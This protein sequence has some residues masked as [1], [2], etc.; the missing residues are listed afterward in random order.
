MNVACL[1]DRLAKEAPAD[2]GFI[3]GDSRL[4]WGEIS[5]RVA[6]LAGVLR[7]RG[8]TRG[9]RVGLL[10][11]N[12]AAYLEVELALARLGAIVQPMNTRLAVPEL[13]AQLADSAPRLLIYSQSQAEAAARAA[14]RLASLAL[15]GGGP[16]GLEAAMPAVEP[17]DDIVEAA[18]EDVFGLFYTSGTTGRPK[19]VM[20]T[21]GNVLSNTRLL[22]PSIGLRRDDVVLHAAPMFHVADFGMSYGQ[23]L[24]GS[25]HCFV[26][27][28]TPSG[29]AE[30]IERHRVGIVVLVPTMIA[31][32]LRDP[33]AASRDL[34]SL[35]FVF[36]GGSPMP[37]ALLR[38]CFERL[39]C[40]FIQGY[41]QT[42]VTHTISLLGE[43]DHRRAL[44]QPSLLRSCGKP[45]AGVELRVV[46]ADDRPVAPGEVGEIVVRAPHV[47]KGYWN[48]P[49]V[50]AEALKGGWLRTGDLG[51]RDAEGY[52]YLVDRKKDMIISGG[53]NV[54]SA[55]VENALAGH[56]S[57]LDCAVI[58]V[59]DETFGERV[60]A[61]VVT[62]PGRA[63][64]AA[65]LQ[66]HCRATI[67]GYKIPRSFE[68]V[69][70]LPKTAAGKVRKALLRAPHWDRP[71][72]GEARLD[73]GLDSAGVLPL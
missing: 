59:P 63:G 23:L 20:I 66:A 3:L 64:D 57:V 52:L 73:E 70:E 38:Q 40:G 60:H 8:V 42:E 14:P 43:A 62:R 65:A 25:R 16:D 51:R 9:D 48:Q 41:G 27:Q 7:S 58:G 47:M 37:E 21:H 4:S 71:H 39:A 46:D 56:D 6:R 32:L 26:P 12:S 24:V 45:M 15:D 50:S 22:V 10:A 72:R 1:L 49:A 28:F 33:A 13:A 53:E 44:E 2:T 18:P 36:Y 61:V 69:A 55:E 31:L 67:A 54:Y 35:R 19:G 29:T 30:A 17:L 34:S 11:A 68:F 5:G